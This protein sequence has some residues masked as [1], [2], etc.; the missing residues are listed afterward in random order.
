MKLLSWNKR[1]VSPGVVAAAFVDVLLRPHGRM[2]FEFQ[3]V[4]ANLGGASL[5]FADSLELIFVSSFCLWGCHHTKN[6]GGKLNYPESSFIVLEFKS[7]SCNCFM[8]SLEL[9]QFKSQM[10]EMLEIQ[11][12]AMRS[13][14]RSQEDYIQGMNF[15]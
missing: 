8:L 9:V 15:G 10:K 4:V 3:Y 5:L 12:E 1:R 7:G 2:L 13:E 11:L 6:F 14:I